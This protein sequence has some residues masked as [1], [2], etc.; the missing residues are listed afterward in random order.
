MAGGQPSSCGAEEGFWMRFVML[1]RR[2]PMVDRLC[3]MAQHG[4]GFGAEGVCDADDAHQ[5]AGSGH[6]QVRILGGHLV[7]LFLL[8][9]GN[10]AVLVLKD[11]VV[12]ADD[13]PL[14]ADPAGNAVGHDVFHFGVHLFVGQ[15]LL[16]GGADHRVGHGVGEMLFQT[17]GQTE[18]IVLLAVAEGDDVHHLRGGAGDV[19]GE[20]IGIFKGFSKC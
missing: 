20:R 6:V 3:S 1:R 4:S 15:I 13:H 14:A 2:M 10:D 9:G 18:H 5:L 7:E 19:A 11:E 16:S 17:G 8:V 12:A